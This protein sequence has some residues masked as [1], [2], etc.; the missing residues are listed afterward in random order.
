MC[1]RTPKKQVEYP[2]FFGQRKWVLDL[3][4]VEI[5]DEGEFLLA[6]DFDMND[7]SDL[8]DGDDIH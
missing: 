8:A 7:E 4:F 6:D 1:S 5:I 2:H 3:P